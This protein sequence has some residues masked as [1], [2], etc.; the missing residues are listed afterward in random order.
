[1]LAELVTDQLECLDDN[2]A[3]SVHISIDLKRPLTA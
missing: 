3:A 1:M 2:K